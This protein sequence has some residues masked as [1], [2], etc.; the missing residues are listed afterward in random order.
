MSGI[1][2]VPPSLRA[3]LLLGFPVALLFTASLAAGGHFQQGCSATGL[4]LVLTWVGFAV[5]VTGALAAGWWASKG[6]RLRQGCLAGVVIG[7]VVVA[8][9]YAA[10]LVGPQHRCE[11]PPSAYP[12]AQRTSNQIQSEVSSVVELVLL[13]GLG[14]LMGARVHRKAIEKRARRRHSV[15]ADT[16]GNHA[17]G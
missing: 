6:V 2:A 1:R 8:V 14:G 9:L 10:I 12:P 11:A 17:G 7:L 13:A 3:G 5:L 4:T 16:T 15:E